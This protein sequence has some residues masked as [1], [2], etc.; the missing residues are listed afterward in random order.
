MANQCPAT[1]IDNIHQ[2]SRNKKSSISIRI[3]VMIGNKSEYILTR[4]TKWKIGK[5]I[6]NG[7]LS[8]KP[9]R[10]S[11]HCQIFMFHYSP[12]KLWFNIF[13]HTHVMSNYALLT[14]C[15]KLSSGKLYDAKCCAILRSEQYHQ[16]YMYERQGSRI[17]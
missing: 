17:Q 2:Y 4:S 5:K 9:G 6:T 10:H 16:H 14:L 3:S 1:A 11:R 12:F 15:A 13:F 7:Q 8:N